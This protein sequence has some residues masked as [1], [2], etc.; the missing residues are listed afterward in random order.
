MDSV[1]I[2]GAWNSLE[3]DAIKTPELSRRGFIKIVGCVG[4]VAATNGLAFSIFKGSAEA[5]EAA[6]RKLPAAWDEEVDVL[7]VGTGFAGMAAAA[8]ASSRGSKVMMIE[9]MPTLGGNSYINGAGFNAW[10]DKLNLREKLNKGSDSADLHYQ[11]TLKGG[12]YYNLPELVKTLVDGAPDALNWLIDQ[13]VEFQPILNKMGGHSAFRSHVYISGLGRGYVDAM[14]KIA[15]SNGMK[16][17][18]STKLTWIWRQDWTGPILGVE[19]EG[20]K[21]KSNIKVKQALILGA[22]GF[23]RDLKMCSTFNPSIT[24][25][26]NCTN[27]PGAT[28]EVIRYAQAIGAD[29]LH[30]AFIQMFPTADPETGALD[31]VGLIP[32]RGGAYGAIFVDKS[33]KRF[34]NESGKRDEVSRAMIATEAK[35]TYCIFSEKMIEK[36]TTAKVV[37]EGLAKG[38]ILKAASIAELAQ[39]AELPAKPFGETVSKHLEYQKKGKDPDFNKPISPTMI[40]LAEGPYYCIAQWPSVHHTMGGLRINSLAQVIDIWGDPIPRLYAA[41]EV[42]GGVHG[43]NRLGSN[44]T[45]D[46]I[47]FGRIAGT[48]AAKEKG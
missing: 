7:I 47:V 16:L 3:S 23:S 6:A 11:D 30:L 32:N 24:K 41:G 1:K 26:C 31:Q 36:M 27:Q 48:N 15:D 42:T 35:A 46:A 8:E 21:G 33:G 19:V 45:P 39:K 12:D 38:R 18:V 29:A 25:D 37:E 20:P 4:T 17:S 2:N 43:N 44:A 13:G 22:G 14:K 34:V 9:K 28:G 10:T 5:A 40:S